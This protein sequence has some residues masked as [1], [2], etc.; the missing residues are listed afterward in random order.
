MATDTRSRPT[1]TSRIS[2]SAANRNNRGG[3]TETL[4]RKY[5]HG[6]RLMPL[7]IKRPAAR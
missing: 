4:V 2:P 1:A 6:T 7:R 5:L 3:P